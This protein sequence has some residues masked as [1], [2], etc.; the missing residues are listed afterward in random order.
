MRITFLKRVSTHLES[1]VSGPQNTP[2]RRLY[3]A[4]SE[5]RVS[6]SLWWTRLNTSL[7]CSA[8]RH[9]E[10]YLIQIFCSGNEKKSVFCSGW[11]T[12]K[13]ISSKYSVHVMQ[14]VLGDLESTEN[15]CLQL[16]WRIPILPEWRLFFPSPE[17]VGGVRKEIAP[18]DGV[19]KLWVGKGVAR[20]WVTSPPSVDLGLFKS[21][22]II[23]Q[24]RKHLGKQFIP[25]LIHAATLNRS[26]D[27]CRSSWKIERKCCR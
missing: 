22:Q 24:L 14:I 12:R 13:S 23:K 18:G 19:G 9:S 11:E 15:C 8:R 1:G 7:F 25:S 27:F 16:P 4:I 6:C 3:T 5:W 26:A 2:Q 20:G 17:N 21:Y 10:T